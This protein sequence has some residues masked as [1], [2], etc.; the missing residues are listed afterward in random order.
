MLLQQ[1]VKNTNVNYHKTF[2][3]FVILAA[4]ALGTGE[5]FDKSPFR[6]TV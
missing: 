5:I 1:V 4:A 6:S 3:L 2:N